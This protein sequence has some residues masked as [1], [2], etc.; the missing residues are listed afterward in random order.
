MASEAVL[1]RAPTPKR[2]SASR[3]DGFADLDDVMQIFR[4][5]RCCGTLSA[6]AT[7]IIQASTCCSPPPSV[8]A[9]VPPPSYSAALHIVQALSGGERA[10]ALD[11]VRAA[12]AAVSADPRE[13]LRAFCA[14][15]QRRRLASETQALNQLSDLSDEG[16]LHGAALQALC[17]AVG[18]GAAAIVRRRSG[19]VQL[20]PADALPDARTAVV[21]WDD[22]TQAYRA[23]G[24]ATSLTAARASLAG[25]EGLTIDA[26][27]RMRLP[28]MRSALVRLAGPPLAAACRKADLVASFSGMLG[29]P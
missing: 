10:Q 13:A 20:A 26:F 25:E 2:A 19:T 4:K 7:S 17:R 3:P 8:V 11:T 29:L 12:E 15:C 16:E 28:E 21:V 9:A 22:C 18:P 5:A 14:S 23:A 24:P 1:P 6:T 27:A